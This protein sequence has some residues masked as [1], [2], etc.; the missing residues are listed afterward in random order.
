MRHPTSFKSRQ[1]NQKTNE[2]AQ[3]KQK[4]E[5]AC[6]QTKQK[7]NSPRAARMLCHV[8][9]PLSVCVFVCLYCSLLF[10][11]FLCLFCVNMR[12]CALCLFISFPCL[13]C[14][15]F[16]CLFAL[17]R[18]SPRGLKLLRSSPRSRGRFFYLFFAQGQA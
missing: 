11:G 15:V 8:L 16:L 9:P 18:P 17:T 7:K 14:G 2:H 13:S 1:I 5:G 6:E 10:N 3:Q 4:N 12:Y